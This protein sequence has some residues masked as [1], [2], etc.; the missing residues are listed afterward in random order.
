MVH[1]ILASFPW[2]SY[3]GGT[4]IKFIRSCQRKY[5]EFRIRGV[6]SALRAAVG[7]KELYRELGD[8]FWYQDY[9]TRIQ[10]LQEFLN[11]LHNKYK[12]LEKE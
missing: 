7:H 11:K 5:L 2:I 10:E 4:V 9:C 1:M 12:E 8:E 3:Y 6:Q